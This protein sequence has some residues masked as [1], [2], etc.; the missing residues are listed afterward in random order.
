MKLLATI[1]LLTISI[2]T[3]AP[4]SQIYST[5][6]Q[7]TEDCC[8]NDT[9][10]SDEQ[11]GPDCCPTGICNPFQVCACCVTIPTE[12]I[13]FQFNPYLTETKNKPT[14]D[15]FILSDFTNDCWQPPETVV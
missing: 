4:I 14:A 1:L 15:K 12:N 11:K 7:C 2:L 5:N 13:S 10:S 8:S 3:V 6:E 9:Q